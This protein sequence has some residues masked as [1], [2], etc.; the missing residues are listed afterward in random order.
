MLIFSL[1]SRLVS[2]NYPLSACGEKLSVDQ[3][4]HHFSQIFH[5]SIF[6][7]LYNLSP[8]CW[9]FRRFGN[10]NYNKLNNTWHICIPTVVFKFTLFVRHCSRSLNPNSIFRVI[11]FNCFIIRIM[12][13]SNFSNLEFF[14]CNNSSEFASELVAVYQPDS[15]HRSG[16]VKWI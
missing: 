4:F 1:P 10:L 14:T 9:L 11:L 7:Y 8:I 2:Q 16:L 6:L 15:T 12:F 5:I 3:F 13:A